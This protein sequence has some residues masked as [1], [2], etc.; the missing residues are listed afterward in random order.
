MASPQLQQWQTRSGSRTSC[1]T[2][3]SSASRPLL[4]HTP[5]GTRSRD[6]GL[7]DSDMPPPKRQRSLQHTFSKPMELSGK[8]HAGCWHPNR[9]DASL[10]VQTPDPSQMGS[11]ESAG[12]PEPQSGAPASMQDD[13]LG[14]AARASLSNASLGQHMGSTAH[15]QGL[16]AGSISCSG[17]LE[18]QT[19]PAHAVPS[20]KQSSYQQHPA[21]F[22]ELTNATGMPEVAPAGLQQHLLA[23]NG[24]HLLAENGKHNTASQEVYAESAQAASADGQGQPMAEQVSRCFQLV[25]AAADA[26]AAAQLSASMQPGSRA[27]NP[28][29]C[30]AKK[31]GRGRPRKQ[32]P[33]S[34]VRKTQDEHGNLGAIHAMLE[35]VQ[36]LLSPSKVLASAVNAPLLSSRSVP[37]VPGLA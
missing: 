29:Q 4:R 14:T 28:D 31:K 30:P 26:V 9:I 7:S 24:K 34:S 16:A 2:P 1:P 17:M 33:E 5:D 36:Q 35:K 32:Q 3:G 19:I 23:E 8:W 15:Q 10:Q 21:R 25:S 37:G 12:R 13:H 20:R 11:P 22:T 18:T 6:Q 27:R